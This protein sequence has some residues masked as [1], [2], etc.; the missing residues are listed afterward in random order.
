M[1]SNFI[2]LNGF[3]RSG[4]SAIS[5]VLAYHPQIE[6][7]M[8]P[9]NS[10]FVREVMNF[11]YK[12]RDNSKDSFLFFD[13]LRN[14]ML[15]NDLIK[16]HWY[17][18]Y[19]TTTVYKENQLHLI[20]TTINHLFQKWMKLNFPDIEV[21][22]IWRDPK[23]IVNSIFRN[24]FYNKWYQN[25]VDEIAFTV[26]NCEIL[27]DHFTPFIN[28]LNS[29]VRKMSFLIA[30]RTYYFLYYLDS[31]KLLNYETFVS[32]YN[33]LNKFTNAYSLT[34]F[35]FN[36]CADID[37]NIVGKSYEN[38]EEIEVS[39]EDEMFMDLIFTELYNLKEEKFIV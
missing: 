30:V 7:I 6:L 5:K 10:G 28:S 25:A 32:S 11:E 16:S 9:F 18:E 33:Y 24:D 38:K 13:S 1:A 21:W 31:D 15:R 27:K 3:D 29:D 34:D 35:N 12:E 36:E 39:L 19:S 22:G 8:Q 14:N 2:I 23:K 37:Y 17:F 4:T 20:K 26:A